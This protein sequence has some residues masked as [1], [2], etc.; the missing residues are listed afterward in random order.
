MVKAPPDFAQLVRTLVVV[1][2]VTGVAE[3]IGQEVDGDN[4]VVDGL[5]LDGLVTAGGADELRY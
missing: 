1:D 3:V 5:D 4:G 2:A